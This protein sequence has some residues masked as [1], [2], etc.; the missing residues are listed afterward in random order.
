MLAFLKSG[1]KLGPQLSIAF[2]QLHGA[3]PE[4][5]VLLGHSRRPTCE[6]GMRPDGP[7]RSPRVLRHHLQRRVTEARAQECAA[8]VRH[9]QEP[10]GP[11]SRIAA[12]GRVREVADDGPSLSTSRRSIRQLNA[13]FIERNAIAERQVKEI[14]RHD[15][16]PDCRKTPIGA[17]AFRD[18]NPIP[19]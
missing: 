4:R 9:Q 18:R 3:V 16:A 14:E 7:T 5:R 15:A 6:R 8:A 11:A 1:G 2:E 10:T 12:G 17:K 13:L 19:A